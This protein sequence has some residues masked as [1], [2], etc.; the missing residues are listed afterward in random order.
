[1][2]NEDFHYVKTYKLRKLMCLQMLLLMRYSVDK[3]EE[4]KPVLPGPRTI[5]TN[6]SLY[7]YIESH[8]ANICY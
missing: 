2:Q 3:R 6:L 5:G 7:F 4:F 8:M 1:M